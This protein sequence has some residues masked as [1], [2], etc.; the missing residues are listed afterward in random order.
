MKR[1]NLSPRCEEKSSSGSAQG[2]TGAGLGNEIG[3]LR[4]EAIEDVTL[5]QNAVKIKKGLCSMRMRCRLKRFI[6]MEISP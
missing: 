1:E 3:R 5:T 6:R 2:L 4:H